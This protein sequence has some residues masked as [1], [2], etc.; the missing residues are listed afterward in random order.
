[1]HKW[2]V[3]FS[4]NCECGVTKQIADH[5]LIACPIHWAPH[6]T[7]DLTVWI[8]KLDAGS[9]P[10]LPTSDLGST[11]AWDSKKIK[12]RSSPVCE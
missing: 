11:A 5:V 1:M 9:T 2:G 7:Q 6:G 10:S 12:P 8:T 4:P 3:D